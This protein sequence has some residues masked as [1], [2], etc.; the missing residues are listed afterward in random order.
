MIPPS[1]SS[2]G[3]VRMKETTLLIRQLIAKDYRQRLTAA[4]TLDIVHNR[5]SRL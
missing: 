1:P 5:L 3:V 4:Q 2:D